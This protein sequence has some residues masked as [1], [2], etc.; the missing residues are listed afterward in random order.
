[1]LPFCSSSGSVICNR[2]WLIINFT[3]P[4]FCYRMYVCIRST[5]SDYDHSLIPFRAGSMYHHYLWKMYTSSKLNFSYPS[6]Y[7]TI[8]SIINSLPDHAVIF[9]QWVCTFMIQV[10]N[11]HCFH[12][13]NLLGNAW[14]ETMVSAQYWFYSKMSCA[15]RH[16]AFTCWVGDLCT[17]HYCNLA[18]AHHNSVCGW[19]KGVL[20]KV[21]MASAVNEIS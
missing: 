16:A 1:M 19:E 8:Q 4:S 7:V 12:I 11:Q 5:W 21:P 3:M 9:I 18:Q 10:Q 6:E 14:L 2:F 15:A 17:S 13:T 20:I